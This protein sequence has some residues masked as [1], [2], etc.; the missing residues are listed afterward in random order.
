MFPL[1]HTQRL[2]PLKLILQVF[3][4]CK[5]KRLAKRPIALGTTNNAGTTNM[6]LAFEEFLR[7]ALYTIITV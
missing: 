5:T 3:R 2:H 7:E 4:G 6:T 1:P